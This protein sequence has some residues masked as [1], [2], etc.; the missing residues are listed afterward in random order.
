[1]FWGWCSV[2]VHRCRV[3]KGAMLREQWE[4]RAQ[5]NP[6]Y[7]LET[8]AFVG[9][10]ATVGNIG[11]ISAMSLS[12]FV[13]EEMYIIIEH[14]KRIFSIARLISSQKRDR[15]TDLRSIRGELAFTNSSSTGE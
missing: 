6:S 14:H 7:G 9:S 1:M 8:A 5:V 12:S 13:P 10:C 4:R 2:L 11:V 3:A 15:T